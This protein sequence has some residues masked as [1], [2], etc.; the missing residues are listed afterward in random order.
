MAVEVESVNCYNRVVSGLAI[1]ERDE[2]F[3]FYV[4]G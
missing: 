4:A 1:S 3:S 2:A